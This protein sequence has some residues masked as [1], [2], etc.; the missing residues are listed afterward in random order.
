MGGGGDGVWNKPG[1]HSL[2]RDVEREGGTRARVRHVRAKGAGGEEGPEAGRV[3]RDLAFFRAPVYYD[4]I[5][6]RCDYQVIHDEA[7]KHMRD[8]DVMVECGVMFGAGLAHLADVARASGK[9]VRIVGV[10]S[11]EDDWPEEH[12]PHPE[13]VTL[14]GPHYARAAVKFIGQ[15]AR[16]VELR[17]QD[18]LEWLDE[19]KPNSLSYVFLDDDHSYDHVKAEILT[20]LAKIRPGGILAGHDYNTGRHHRN[21]V[22]LAVEELLPTHRRFRGQWTHSWWYEKS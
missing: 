13:I 1:K 5:P 2:W 19:Q 10:D 20:A 21:S 3:R 7:I 17:Q 15:S 9:D 18:A 12:H 4:G 6:G 16:R 11:W 14:A 22:A 8:G